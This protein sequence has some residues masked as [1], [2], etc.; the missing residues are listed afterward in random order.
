L[1]SATEG[2]A[3]LATYNADGLLDNSGRRKIC[4]LTVK[5]ELQEDSEKSVKTQR[6]LFFISREQKFPLKN[7]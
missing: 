5:R 7:I 4:N 2:K 1:K 3:L 6:L